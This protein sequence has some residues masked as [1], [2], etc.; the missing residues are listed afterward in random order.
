MHA[1]GSA[2][3]EYFMREQYG[4]DTGLQE[5]TVQ[6]HLVAF[7][8]SGEYIYLYNTCM[9][10]HE[11]LNSWPFLGADLPHHLCKIPLPAAG[12]PAHQV[13]TTASCC[14]CSEELHPSISGY[15]WRNLLGSGSYSVGIPRVRSS[16]YF[17]SNATISH[18][19]GCECVGGAR[20]DR[21][22]P[23]LEVNLSSVVLCPL[24]TFSQDSSI[25]LRISVVLRLGPFTMHMVH[26]SGTFLGS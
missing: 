2:T 9:S 24:L 6:Y 14:D 17:P 16:S 15:L 18:S 26:R 4:S 20:C 23:W 13:C 1:T 3:C 8:I 22:S 11:P 25:T 10:H 19:V 21:S 12:C 5:S 7:L